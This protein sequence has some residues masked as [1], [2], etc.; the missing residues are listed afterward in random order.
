MCSPVNSC[1]KLLIPNNEIKSWANRYDYPISE[2]NLINQ[3]PQIEKQGYLTKNILEQL[4]KWKS[5]RSAGNMKRNSEEYI[6]EITQISFQTKN[7]RT[8]IEVLT[9]LD[10]VDWPTASA[11]LHLFD[12][13][14][15]PLL[16]FRALWSISIENY[17]YNFKFWW[18][19]VLFTRKISEKNNI[20]MRTLDRA[21]WQYSK[22]NQ[23]V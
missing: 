7:E 1:M 18:D 9:L 3:K 17:K 2:T 16:D 13:N 14:K 12:K 15:Y 23:P 20:D 4:C 6:N 11:I 8:T 22:N 19:Y 10:G 5:P 21:L